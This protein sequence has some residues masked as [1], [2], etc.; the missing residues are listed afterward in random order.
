MNTIIIFITYL[1][2]V[3]LLLASIY[4]RDKFTTEF[5]KMITISSFFSY[6]GYVT[7]FWS[8]DELKK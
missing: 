7:F 2:I 4:G 6:I 3:L 8:I 5:Y 1:I